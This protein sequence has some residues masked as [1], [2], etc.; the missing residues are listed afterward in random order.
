[1]MKFKILTILFFTFCFL[2]SFGQVLSIGL[3]ANPSFLDLELKLGQS[4]EVKILVYNISKEAG[5]FKVFPDDLNDWIKITPDN[6]RLEAGENKEV[7]IEIIAKENGRKTTNL[8][9]SAIPLDRSSF[10]VNPGLKI[11]LRLNVE[12]KKEFF[13]A[14]VF[15]A[16]NRD[17]FLATIIIFIICLMG[18]FLVK[19]IRRRG[20]ILFFTLRCGSDKKRKSSKIIS[21]PENLPIE[22]L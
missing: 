11:P 14:S 4:K 20:Q 7:R 12:G 19:Y 3:G 17:A 13:L 2:F 1:M 18:F 9:A 15:E 5:I 21:P 22:K 16:F 8:S 10:S 6:F